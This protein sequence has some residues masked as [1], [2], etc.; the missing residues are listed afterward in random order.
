MTGPD[1]HYLQHGTAHDREE[2][3][4]GVCLHPDHDYDGEPIGLD[5]LIWA[6]ES[7]DWADWSAGLS[8]ESLTLSE[9]WP[10]V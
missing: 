6:D 7:A 8:A 9:G 3:I 2:C 5:F 4:P 1:E 10:F